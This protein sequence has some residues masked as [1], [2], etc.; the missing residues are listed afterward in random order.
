MAHRPEERAGVANVDLSGTTALVTGSTR[1]I[2]RET[3]EAL[4]RLGAHVLVH[5][6][7]QQT[8]RQVVE[9]LREDGTGAEFLRADF[10]NPSEVRDLAQRVRTMSTSLDV[11][12]NNAG[13][14]FREG[15]LTDLGVERTFAVNHLAPYLLTTELLPAMSDDGRI[16]TVA[17]E[18]HRGAALD[19]DRATAVGNYSALTAYQQS[20]LA[21]ILF[22]LELAR[23]LRNID[24]RL[25]SNALHPGTVPGSG[26]LRDLPGPLYRIARA[27][28]GFP[29]VTSVA[30]GAETPT[31]LA[32]APAVDGVTGAY[33]S[34]CARRTPARAARNEA[35]ARELWEISAQ[36]LGIEEPLKHAGQRSREAVDER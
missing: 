34:E 5:G 23:R 7:D 35:T 32:A 26:F 12:V 10:S 27:L 6:R 4:G 17:S 3:A 33:F 30:E 31:Y 20:K 1:G 28:D 15:R 25:T 13:G 21:N 8:G 18:A 2:G 16:V 29:L 11:L 22:A 24:G 36:L 19:L 14:Y 9:T